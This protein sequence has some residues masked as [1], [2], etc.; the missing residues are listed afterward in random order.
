MAKMAP[1]MLE[2]TFGTGFGTLSSQKG[3]N[4]IF[5]FPNS[6][7]SEAMQQND[8]IV[9]GWLEGLDSVDGFDNPSGPLYLDNSIEETMARP[10]GGTNAITTLKTTQSC[11]RGCACC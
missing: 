10:A 8:H 9:S 7:R 6:L 1:R 4:R 11:A 2:P 5:L 3:W